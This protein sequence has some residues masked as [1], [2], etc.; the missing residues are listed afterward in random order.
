MTSVT[1]IAAS[2]GGPRK[3]AARSADWGGKALLVCALAVLMAAGF[4]DTGSPNAWQI[5]HGPC[6]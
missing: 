6:F 2:N 3:L 5:Y 1:V 4:D